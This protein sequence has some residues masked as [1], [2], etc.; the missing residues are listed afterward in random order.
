MESRK[1]SDKPF[2]IVIAKNLLEIKNRI[3]AAARRSGRPSSD[4]TLVAVCKTQPAEKI[5]KALAAGH[6]DFGENYAQEL[7]EHLTAV[8]AY[9]HAPLHEET[10]WHFIGHLQRNKVKLVMGKVSLIHSVDSLELA[11]EIEKRAAAMERVQPVLVEVNVGGESSKTGLKPEDVASLVSQ[12]GL[13]E[14]VS[15]RGLMTI[16][17]A[18]E[19]LEDTRAH[20]RLL[21]EIRED[22]NRESVYKSPL[23]ELS[24]GMTHDFEIAIEEGATIVRVGTGI[25]GERKKV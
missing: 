13:L 5:A 25:F 7:V 11:Q 21:R 20:F 4:V 1:N 17:P 19:D 15:L 14:H 12:I 8:G 6:H 10:H 23:V 2:G 3:A 18:S 9:G 24:M 16:P 22:L